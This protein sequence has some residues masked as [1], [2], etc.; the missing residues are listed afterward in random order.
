MAVNAAAALA[1]VGAVG[2]DLHAG[3][4]AMAAVQLSAMRMEVLRTPAGAT[5]LND[6]YN[7]NPTSM[8]AAIDAL[9]ALPAARRV[10]V[11]G[12]MAEIADAE[13]EHRQMVAYAVE[14]GVEVLAF[15]TDL[16]GVRA[17]LTVDEAVAA[18]GSIA[19]GDAVLVKGSRVVG[20][21]RLAATLCGAGVESA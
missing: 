13:V 16:Y 10:A 7:A 19:G 4:H 2:G 11:L 15:G 12:L 9:A 3:A 5:V 21:E 18:L 6:A 1:C 14:R 20:L 8:R 17:V